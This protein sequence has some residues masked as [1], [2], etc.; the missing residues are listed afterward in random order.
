MKKIKKTI[1]AI[2]PNIRCLGKNDSNKNFLH[3]NSSEI[4]AIKKACVKT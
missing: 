3:I 2:H 1:L 4:G